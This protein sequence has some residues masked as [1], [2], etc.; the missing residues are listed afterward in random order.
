MIIICFGSINLVDYAFFRLLPSEQS[1]LHKNGVV[2]VL[3]EE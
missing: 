3:V 1:F 2:E